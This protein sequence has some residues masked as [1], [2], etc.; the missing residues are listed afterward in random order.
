MNFFFWIYLYI[1][2]WILLFI[3]H[4]YSKYYYVQIEQIIFIFNLLIK[5][6]LKK[7]KKNFFYV[8]NKWINK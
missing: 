7:K 8:I 6:F 4:Y 3:S 2:L 1:L 5:C